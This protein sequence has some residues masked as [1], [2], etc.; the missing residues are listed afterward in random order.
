MPSHVEMQNLT[1][2]MGDDEKA[3]ENAEGECSAVK[4]PVT[5]S[6]A[7][8]ERKV[9]MGK[10]PH[11]PPAP[12]LKA[13]L[14]Q[15][16]KTADEAACQTVLQTDFQIDQV[17]TSQSVLLMRSAIRV[18]K[19]ALP[20]TSPELIGGFFADLL[21]LWETGQRLD[22]ELLKLK[23]LRFPRDREQL[24]SFLIW[25]SAI[26]IDMASFWIGGA[27]KYLPKLLRAVDR[28]EN[29]SSS[30]PKQKPAKARQAEKRKILPSE[31]APR[32]RK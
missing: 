17:L 29:A 32:R 24:R 31:K 13:S 9:I 26:Q 2:I 10:S 15:R 30:K 18:F 6:V 23:E 19:E 7:S 12:V 8:V 11:G 1:P 21:D 25:I 28:L 5:N 22:K 3:I 4:F 20:D 14:R 27:K 16:G